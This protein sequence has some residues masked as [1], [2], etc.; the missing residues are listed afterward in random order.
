MELRSDSFIPT[1]LRIADSDRPKV[2]DGALTFAPQVQPRFFFVFEIMDRRMDGWYTS[3]RLLRAYRPSKTYRAGERPG[4]GD[5]MNDNTNLAYNDVEERPKMPPHEPD[6]QLNYVELE[7][8][9]K[10]LAHDDRFHYLM[11][12]HHS[13]LGYDADVRTPVRCRLYPRQTKMVM[14]K[15]SPGMEVR[16]T[17]HLVADSIGLHIACDDIVYRAVRP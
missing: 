8:T 5:T 12:E 7:G 4:K 3:N 15:L 9:V 11:I 10:A 14:E 13:A 16:I 6:Y 1:S 2:Q 17:G